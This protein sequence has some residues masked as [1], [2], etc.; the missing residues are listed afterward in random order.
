MAGDIK[1][2]AGTT[3]SAVTSGGVVNNGAAAIAN[4]NANLANSANLDQFV[5]ARL[6]TAAAANPTEGTT[7]A[8][9]LVPK[10]DGANVA[11]VDTSTPFIPQNY[12]V[13]NFVWPATGV[14]TSKIMDIDGIPLSAIDYV[15]YII[16]NLGQNMSSGW[17]LSFYGTRSQYTP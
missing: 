1:E 4:G 11:D 13:G 16:N 17:T 8:L 10:S 14:A 5:T 2:K 3:T 7:V 9:Y 15:P 12:F 6:A